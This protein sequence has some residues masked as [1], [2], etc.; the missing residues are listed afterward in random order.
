MLNTGAYNEE[1]KKDVL[2]NINRSIVFW[3]WE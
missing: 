1:I 3:E 2:E